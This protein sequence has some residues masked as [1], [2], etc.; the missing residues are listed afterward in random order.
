MEM[1]S[2]NKI[3]LIGNVGQEPEIKTLA[4]NHT[5][6]KISLAT[7][8]VYHQKDGTK[9]ST[10]TWHTILA[11]NSLAQIVQDY[12]HKGSLLHIQGK[13]NYRK[14]DDPQGNLHTITEIIADEIIMLDKK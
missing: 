5:V 9:T 14:Y 4:N 1:K 7:T 2:L 10:T 6:A 12:I 3:F 13:I 8:E 11:W